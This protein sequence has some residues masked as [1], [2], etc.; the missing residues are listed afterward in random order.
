MR[1][2]HESFDHVCG[3]NDHYTLA[4][5]TSEVKTTIWI[6]VAE[7]DFQRILNRFFD[8]MPVSPHFRMVLKHMAV[9]CVI[10][11]RDEAAERIAEGSVGHLDTLSQLHPIE[12]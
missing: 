1:C 7:A 12:F 9:P 3:D 4:R 2:L 11:K 10:V 6:C 5:A 8:Q